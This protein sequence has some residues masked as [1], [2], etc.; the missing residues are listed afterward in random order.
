MASKNLKI[1]RKQ[2][3]LQ[4]LATMLERDAGGRITLAR[5]A[6]EVGISEAALYRHFENKAAMFEALIIFIEETLFSRI[7]RILSEEKNL[8]GRLHNI[9]MLVL[10]FSARNPGISRLMSGD[11]L[12]GESPGLRERINQM[13]NR[14]QTQLKQIIRE[15]QAQHPPAPGTDQSDLALAQSNLILAYIEGRIR[16]FVRSDFRSKPL[17]QAESQ[18]QLLA[19]MLG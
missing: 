6:K 9:V 5:L 15:A 19:T 16:Q 17:A 3:I 4:A 7:T 18:W 1:S 10:T 13:F 2:Q 14:L 11:A 12:M 8:L